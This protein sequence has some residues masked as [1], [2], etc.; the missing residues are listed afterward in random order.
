[1]YFLRRLWCFSLHAYNVSEMCTYFNYYATMQPSSR[2]Y[3]N[4]VKVVPK[5]HRSNPIMA[6]LALKD[7]NV[8]VFHAQGLVV[9]RA[10]GEV[11]FD[12]CLFNIFRFRSALPCTATAAFVHG[13]YRGFKIYC[14][15]VLTVCAV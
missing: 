8:P 4:A 10:N 2:Q 13:C 15:C 1:M 14:Y 11:G 12:D 9:T 6:T 5:A 3:E 7:V